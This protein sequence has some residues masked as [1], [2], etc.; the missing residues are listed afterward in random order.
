M[1]FLLLLLLLLL[2]VGLIKERRRK[3]AGLKC[4]FTFEK[5]KYI[6]SM[7]TVRRRADGG[8]RGCWPLAVTRCW[9]VVCDSYSRRV[10]PANDEC[11]LIIE[12][13]GG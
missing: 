7:R 5:T 1:L 10:L 2:S 6:R 13:K 8:R 3:G 4:V 9:L 12:A 11:R